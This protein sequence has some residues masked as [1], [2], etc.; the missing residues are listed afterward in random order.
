MPLLRRPLLGVAL[1]AAA[2]LAAACHVGVAKRVSYSVRPMAVVPLGGTVTDSRVAFAQMFC[3]V[4]PH[5]DSGSWGACAP[6]LDAQVTAPAPMDSPISTPLK[7]MLVGGAF[8]ECFEQERLYVYGKSL[9][10]METHGVVFG[11]RVK[12]GG[13]ATPEANARAIEE[14]LVRNEG[15]Y[16][17]IGHS[18]GAADLMAAVATSAIAQARIKALVSVSGAIGG[19]RLADL[20][21]AIGVAGFRSALRKAGI[22]CEIEDQGGIASLRRDVRYA[23]LRAW[24]PPAALRTYS[25]AAVS[26]LER[27]SRPLHT[28]WRTNAIYS[29]DQDSHIIA[30]EA[31]IPGSEFIGV[32]HGDHWAV[33]LPM[34]EHTKTKDKVDW[35]RFPRTALLEAIVRYVVARQ[36]ASTGK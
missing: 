4:L 10:H 19:S 25:L 2:T 26:T 35:N 8:S 28:M 22:D 1:A 6:Y 5:T 17:A 23:A 13:T 36:P 7:V 20:G 12:I 14:Y 21:P 34:S 18:K 33:A 9:A 11:P 15:D 16:I 32:A 30:E 29:I 27:T 31:I 24:K 3:A